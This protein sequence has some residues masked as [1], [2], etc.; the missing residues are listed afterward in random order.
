MIVI[1]S[2]PLFHRPDEYH[3]ELNPFLMYLTNKNCK[4]LEN[5]FSS[6]LKVIVLY[7]PKGYG[8]PFLSEVEQMGN[9][10]MFVTNAL[11]LF[12]LLADYKPPSAEQLQ[13]M[14]QNCD[15]SV[16]KIL[17]HFMEQNSN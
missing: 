13:L 8:I 3:L 4:N 12:L 7:D 5:L 15:P 2:Q 17:R 14:I 10:E 9:H 16:Y 1:L 6:L 11:H